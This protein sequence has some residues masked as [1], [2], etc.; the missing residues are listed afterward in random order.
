[1]TIIDAIH[2]TFEIIGIAAV[3]YIAACYLMRVDDWLGPMIEDEHSNPNNS[4][5]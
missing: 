1:M 5:G 2:I 4:K 3:I